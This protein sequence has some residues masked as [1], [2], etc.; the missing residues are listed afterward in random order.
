MTDPMVAKMKNSTGQASRKSPV[1]PRAESGR[2]GATSLVTL[3]FAD[4]CAIT[5]EQLASEVKKSNAAYYKTL[6]KGELAAL[7]DQRAVFVTSK[8]V[9]H[10]EFMEG[11][12]HRG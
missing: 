10:E 3:R 9:E 8:D 1:A 11:Q 2:V 6:S 7:A 12:L 5:D 4:Y